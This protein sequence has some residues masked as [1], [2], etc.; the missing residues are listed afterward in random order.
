MTEEQY[1]LIGRILSDEASSLE[2]EA[3]NVWLNASAGN[4]T[5]F[6][7][8]S[9]IWQ[10]TGSCSPKSIPE[11]ESFWQGM[12]NRIN[13]KETKIFPFKISGNPILKRLMATAA[14]LLVVVSAYFV[15]N[16]QMDLETI[17][18]ETAQYKSVLLVDGS[19][20]TLNGASEI[21]FT[22]NFGSAERKI[23]LSGQAFFEVKK[24]AKP[25]IAETE[26]ARIKVLGTTFDVD[27]RNGA[28]Q[29]V[30]ERGHVSL[31]TL[32]EENKIELLKNQSGSVSIK[33]EIS[34]VKPVDA[35]KLLSW[36]DTILVFNKTPLTDVARQLEQFYGIQIDLEEEIAG[37]QLTGKFRNQ[38]P[39]EVIDLV[40][41]A[42]N[43]HYTYE[44]DQVTI[45]R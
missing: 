29:V 4:K 9:A 31:S 5:E 11:F 3:F 27:S 44:N 38:P 18:T 45:S 36:L 35:Y 21:Q 8:I 34:A 1:I 16:K 40:C 22:R 19:R 10:K 39:R 42:L 30:V 25:F 12:E 15:F 7:K 41:L 14:I 17:Q 24:D 33:G 43:L 28:T 6:E 37:L 23:R 13:Q 2:K 20:V 32:D 26:N